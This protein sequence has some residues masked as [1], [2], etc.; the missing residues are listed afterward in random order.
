MLA[1]LELNYSRFTIERSIMNYIKLT[2]SLVSKA[3]QFGANAAEVYLETGRNLSIQVRDGEVE[4]I[5]EASSAGVGFRVIVEGK[6]GF[7]HCN[8]LSNNALEDTLKRAIEFAKLTT[9]D[10]NNLLPNDKGYTQVDELYD[11]EIIKI[12]MDKKIQMAINLEKLA[13]KDPRITKSSGAGYGE[14][15]GEVF[16]ANSN[17]LSKNF[18]S[19]S[20]NIGVSVVAEKDEQKN[21]GDESCSRRYF[22]DLLPLEEIASKAAKK[23]W[24]LLDP[25]MIPTQRAAVIFDPDVARSLIGGILGALNGERVTQ[26][27]SFLKDYL[28]KP[29]ASP[30]LTIIDDGTRAKG[31]GSAPFDGEG[32]PTRK[33]VLVEKGVVRGFI[34]NTIVAHRAGT[35]ST[36]NASRGG[37]TSLPGIGT[38]NLYIEAGTNTP[39]EIIKSTDKGLLLKEVTGYGIDPVT[40]NFSG[41][42]TGFWIENGEI[43]H[44]VQG[45]T[46]AGNALNILNDI[47]MMGNDLDMNRGMAAPTFRVKEMQI[48]GM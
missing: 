47:D 4:T 32:V 10:S 45:V 20:C 48:G 21:T 31:M 8:D 46:I 42:A 43:K 12:P 29:F 40:G 6:M 30:L 18:K 26:G 14:G 13:M 1:D 2:E 36:G 39:A 37:F 17:G 22:A 28:D 23:A 44:P 16:I 33:R 3:K 35:T 7:S 24:E 41:G 34:Y 9:P 25:V 38:H 15:E 11:P 5:E 19:T 27:A